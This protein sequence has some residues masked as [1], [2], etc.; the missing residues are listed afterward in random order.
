[1]TNATPSS[2]TII[3]DEISYVRRHDRDASN[4]QVFVRPSEFFNS[5]IIDYFTQFFLNSI[6]Y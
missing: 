2:P 5:T 6:Q 3:A 1:M 4:P